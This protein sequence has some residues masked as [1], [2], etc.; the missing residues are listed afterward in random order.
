[1]FLVCWE[2]AMSAGKFAYGSVMCLGLQFIWLISIEI[3]GVEGILHIAFCFGVLI[4]VSFWVVGACGGLIDLKVDLLTLIGC[5]DDNLARSAQVAIGKGEPMFCEGCIKWIRCYI[6]RFVSWMSSVLFEL[7]PYIGTLVVCFVDL[8]YEG[9]ALSC[10]AERGFLDCFGCMSLGVV[11]A[12][13]RLEF[14]HLTE[15][16]MGVRWTW[17]LRGLG[18]V[19]KLVSKTSTYW[20]CYGTLISCFVDRFRR[21]RWTFCLKLWVAGDLYVLSMWLKNC[22]GL[23]TITGDG[24]IVYLIESWGILCAWVLCVA[25]VM[26][27]RLMCEAMCYNAVWNVCV[28]LLYICVIRARLCGFKHWI[29]GRVVGFTYLYYVSFRCLLVGAHVAVSTAC[30]FDLMDMGVNLG[31]IIFVDLQFPRLSRLCL[32]HM[33]SVICVRH[34]SGIYEVGY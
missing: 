4:D 20:I 24:R 32:K 9:I 13:S 2:T 21:K 10:T 12:T 17:G 27:M 22:I 19:V 3:L 31:C 15:R 29:L 16:M 6:F 11:F 28:I 5:L 14:W 25:G 33:V 1:M 18:V 30:E 26:V 7:L 34:V 8:Q 23:C